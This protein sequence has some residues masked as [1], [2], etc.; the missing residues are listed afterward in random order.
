MAKP[1]KAGTKQRPKRA[2]QDAPADLPFEQSVG[3]QIRLTHRIVQRYLQAKIEPH[4]VTLGMWYFL[5]TLWSED[6]LTQRE[7]SHRIGIMEP[8]TL[9][10]ILAMERSGLVTRVRNTDDRRKV[11]IW[12]TPKGRALQATLLPLAIEVVRTA[13]RGFSQD[14]VA[15][16]L[17]MLAAV[18]SNLSLDGAERDGPGEL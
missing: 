2:R 3:Y 4:G 17:G 5:R 6:G 15:R 8:S 13:T 12:L 7:L 11:N 9:T 16:F 1:V 18:Q 10:A 14:E